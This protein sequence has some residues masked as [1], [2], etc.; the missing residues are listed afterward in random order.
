M[1]KFTQIKKYPSVS[2]IIYFDKAMFCLNTAYSLG[3]GEISSNIQLFEYV[4]GIFLKRKIVM[5]RYHNIFP[6]P[7]EAENSE[8]HCLR[9]QDMMENITGLNSYSEFQLL[10]LMS[11]EFLR[12]ALEGEDSQSHIIAPAA[13]V[14]LA[15]LHFATSEYQIVIDL[16]SE[17]LMDQKSHIKYETLNAGCLF[18]INHVARIV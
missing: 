11:K 8:C 17:I 6:E 14:Y 16:C 13:L 9:A 1:H 2:I 10:S 18:F 12:N 7:L 3:S 4:K 15:A 5:Y